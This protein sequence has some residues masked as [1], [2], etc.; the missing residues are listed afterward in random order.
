MRR[1]GNSAK[2]KKQHCKSASIEK[3]FCVLL[4]FPL[5]GEI[6]ALT[7]RMDDGWVDVSSS[8]KRGDRLALLAVGEEQTLGGNWSGGCLRISVRRS[9]WCFEWGWG[10]AT[11]MS[12]VAMVMSESFTSLGVGGGSVS[13]RP[14]N[15]TKEGETNQNKKEQDKI[16]GKQS[17]GT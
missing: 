9:R 12:V 1:A 8:K 14:W 7:R 2:A 4:F 11:G 6:F 13:G 3:V 16:W 17:T 15:V 5:A 10:S